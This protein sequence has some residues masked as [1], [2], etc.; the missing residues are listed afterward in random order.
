MSKRT[1]GISTLTVGL[2]VALIAGGARVE[3]GRVSPTRV[4]TE[5]AEAG[6]RSGDASGLRLVRRARM[7]DPYDD[8]G[9]TEPAPPNDD[10]DGDG[11]LDGFDNCLLHANSQRDPDGDGFGNRCDPDLDND[12]DVDAEDRALLENALVAG[13]A[14]PLEERTFDL[15]EN[16]T[17]DGFDLAIVDEFLGGAPGPRQD[18][19]GDGTADADDR[20]PETP[21]GAG[22]VGR[23]CSALDAM[24]WPERLTAPLARRARGFAARIGSSADRAGVVFFLEQAAGDLSSAAD[25]VRAGDP[26]G[27][28]GP[29]SAAQADFESARAE[30]D[31]VYENRV[32]AIPPLGEE[33]HVSEA[34]IAVMRVLSEQDEVD[35]LIAGTATLGGEFA[36]L[37]ET[38]TPL[39]DSGVVERVDDSLGRMFLTDGRLIGLMDPGSLEGYPGPGSTVLYDGFDLG[40][41]YA[42]VNDIAS[43]GGGQGSGI[44]TCTQFR[45]VPIQKF[46]NPSVDGPYDMFVPEAYETG[47]LYRF[48]RGMRFGAWSICP[49]NQAQLSFK[50]HSLKLTVLSW[51][52]SEQLLPQTQV[53]AFDL[54]PGATPVALPEYYEINVFDRLTIRVET[55]ERTCS[56]LPSLT[57]QDPVVFQTREYPLDKVER[58]SQCALTYA[59]TEFAIDDQ[60][61]GAWSQTWIT[62]VTAAFPS[63]S[64]LQ[65]RGVGFEMCP[66]QGGGWKPCPTPSTIHAPNHSFV[67]QSWDF[68]PVGPT[69]EADEI[70]DHYPYSGVE[71]AAGLA[72]P[73]VR[74]V[75]NGRTWQFSC[76]VP[77]VVR[78][79]V[80]IDCAGGTD[81]FYRL[82]YSEDDGV[83]W[84]NH[85]KGMNGKDSGLAHEQYW[86]YDMG[87]GCGD[88]IRT[89]RAGTVVG[90]RGTLTC[91]RRENCSGVQC[92]SECCTQQQI[93]DGE[94]WGNNVVVRH[95][96]D[97][98]SIYLHIRPGGVAVRK[99][100]KLRRGEIVGTIG[101]TGR[102]QGPHLHFQVNDSLGDDILGLFECLDP[103]DTTQV[104]TCHE[105]DNGEPLYSNNQAVP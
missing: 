57:C 88:T 32:A 40:G 21:A 33:Q 81:A 90:V 44:G 97:T 42:S 25:D 31:L 104:L 70:E 46:V 76:G 69:P 89:A 14:S 39:S 94:H 75:N 48:E 91:K 96:D 93:D 59:E 50:R 53:I 41:G 24:Q 56:L 30:L 86:A 16:G 34:E 64:A 100:E 92:G 80:N 5:A 98:E 82:P 1:S 9:G 63:T 7:I 78:D 65:F 66:A 52:T 58:G 105:P 10:T 8:D 19:D 18:T 47:G 35:E 20:C 54:A 74:G 85:F 13:A 43:E 36:N 22:E 23:G 95:Q 49:S 55:L 87:G 45:F 28:D 79:Y 2:A 101:T 3:A 15:D 6:G 29:L 27:A 26:C 71:R 68:F 61:P 99:G 17:L 83:S 37:C 73:R 51:V 4:G 62:N 60:V 12:G 77:R 67:L 11:T 103:D 72:W 102:S 84:E 38:A